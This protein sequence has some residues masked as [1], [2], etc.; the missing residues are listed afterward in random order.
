[1]L[2]S[3]GIEKPPAEPAPAHPGKGIYPGGLIEF[4]S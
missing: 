1:M 3:L 4:T 2:E